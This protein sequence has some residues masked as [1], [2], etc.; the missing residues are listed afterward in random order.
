MGVSCLGFAPAF[1][2]VTAGICCI[3]PCYQ[4]LLS[5]VFGGHNHAKPSR[6]DTPRGEEKVTFATCSYYRHFA[7]RQ[8]Q[9]GIEFTWIDKLSLTEQILSKA[10]INNPAPHSLFSTHCTVAFCVNLDIGRDIRHSLR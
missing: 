7:L 8:L 3:T 5:G 9:V 10:Q 6:F 2:P 1:C 4:Q